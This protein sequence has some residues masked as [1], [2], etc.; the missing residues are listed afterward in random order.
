MHNWE[1]NVNFLES[2][3]MPIPSKILGH[4]WNKD[5]DTLELLAKPFPQEHPLT[6]RTILSYLETVYDPF[7]IISPTM[8]EEKHI[9]RKA[10]DKQKGWNAEV[11]PI[12]KNQWLRWTKQLKDVRVPRSI[13]SFVGEI[14]AIH[15]HLFADVSILACYA[16]AVA[17]VEHEAGM[18]KGLLTSKKIAETAGAIN[19]TWKYC[20]SELNL[21]DLGS[22][23]ATI[24]KMERANWFSGADWLLDK[25]RWPKQPRLNSTKATDEE[26]KVTQGEVLLTQERK[27]DGWDA[28]LERST[29]WR[30]RRVTAW[31]Y[32]ETAK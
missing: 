30:T 18:T 11:S 31:V 17:V 26:S 2:E 15:L 3:C 1:S 12:L 5:D 16:A 14:G 13:A 24:V 23:E 32:A 29:S 19:S 20:S 10:C 4:A 6:K 22:R 27:F 8:A 25:R 9:Y 28:L 21:T 7:G